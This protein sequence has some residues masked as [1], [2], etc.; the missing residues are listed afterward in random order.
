MADSPKVCRYLHMPAQSGS[1]RIL[2]AMNRHYTAAH[3]LEML[4]KAQDASCRTSPSRATSSSAFPTRPKRISRPLWNSCAGPDTRIASCSSTRPV[5]ARQPTNAW[6]TRSRKRS[7]KGGTS[8]CWPCRNEISEELSREFLGCDVT[9][10]VEGLS[11]KAHVNPTDAEDRPQLVGRTS[12]DHIVVFNGPPSLAGRFR[13]GPH[14]ADLAADAVRGACRRLELTED[15]TYGTDGTDGTCLSTPRLLIAP[16]CCNSH[17]E[18]AAC[19]PA[20]SRD[21]V[22]SKAGSFG[23]GRGRADNCDA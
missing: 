14:H 8:S 16:D 2:R 17:A 21:G 10:L 1:D 12:T 13:P 4:E 15:R 11:K 9:V 22:K 7:S 19:P 23:V 5:R 6:P 20:S 18:T 3:Y